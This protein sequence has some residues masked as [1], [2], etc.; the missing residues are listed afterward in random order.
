VLE[1]ARAPSSKEGEPESSQQETRM[2][3]GVV[4]CGNLECLPK[5]L[6][7]EDFQSRGSYFKIRSQGWSRRERLEGEI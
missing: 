5:A 7:G 4:Y 2:N 6:R 1:N 3:L